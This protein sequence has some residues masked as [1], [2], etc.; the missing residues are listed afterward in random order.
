MAAADYRL[1]DVCNS[2]AFYFADRNYG[3]NR[4]K[5]GIKYVGGEHSY[6]D[7]DN[8]GDWAVLCKEC[9]KTHTTYI[10]KKDLELFSVHHG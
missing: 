3:I 10:M 2:K 6:Q 1:C 5:T 8:L 7:L 4:S 9:A